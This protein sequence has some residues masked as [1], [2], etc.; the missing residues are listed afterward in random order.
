MLLKVVVLLEVVGFGHGGSPVD[1][2]AP[3]GAKGADSTFFTQIPR[4]I[5]GFD[6]TKAAWPG[7]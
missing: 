5:W 4:L 1:G 7:V 6:A 3:G 2:C